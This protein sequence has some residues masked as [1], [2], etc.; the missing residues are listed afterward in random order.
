MSANESNSR[1]NGLSCP[2]KRGHPPV[3]QVK[4]AGEDDKKDGVADGWA[5]GAGIGDVRSDDE[6]Q[7]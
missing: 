3:Q 5:E 6:R 1:P 4:N 2:P 7:R